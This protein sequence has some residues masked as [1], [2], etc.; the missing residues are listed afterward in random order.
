MTRLGLVK[1]SLEE[2]EGGEKG[3]ESKWAKRH[4]ESFEIKLYNLQ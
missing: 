1:N 3:K 2:N 4:R